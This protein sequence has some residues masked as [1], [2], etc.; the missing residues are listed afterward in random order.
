[1]T[2]VTTY[3]LNYGYSTNLYCPAAF[4]HLIVASCN[5]GGGIVLN[6]ASFEL[7]VGSNTWQFYLLPNANAATG[8]HCQLPSSNSYAQA[9]LRC[10]Q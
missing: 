10:S 5:T 8:V 6:D 3:Y 9:Q 2:S 7:P 4:P 1:M